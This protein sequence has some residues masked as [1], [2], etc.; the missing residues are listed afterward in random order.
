MINHPPL[1]LRCLLLSSCLFRSP[2]SPAKPQFSGRGAISSYKIHAEHTLHSATA[3]WT[4]CWPLPI[5]EPTSAT[6]RRGWEIKITKS[7]TW[8]SFL[9]SQFLS[10]QRLYMHTTSSTPWI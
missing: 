8:S 10:S 6:G 2:S 7:E 9:S 4:I 3:A 5:P 1:H